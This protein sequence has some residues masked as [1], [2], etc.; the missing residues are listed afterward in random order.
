[1]VSVAG[2][3]PLL[4]AIR[5]HGEKERGQS[6]QPKKIIDSRETIAKL[7]QHGASLSAKVSTFSP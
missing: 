5:E 7:L 3:T 2:A 4:F 1:L 6:N